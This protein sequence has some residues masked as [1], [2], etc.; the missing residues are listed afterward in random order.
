MSAN[1]A[2]ARIL[3]DR[4]LGDSGWDM[5]DQKQVRLKVHSANT[6]TDYLLFDF[7]GRVLC[8]LEAK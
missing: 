8:V 1:E 5:L 3:I 6:R 2:F 7:L 4:A